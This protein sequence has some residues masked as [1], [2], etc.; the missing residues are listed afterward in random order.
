M[1]FPDITSDYSLRVT[2]G[3]NL[4]VLIILVRIATLILIGIVLLIIALIIALIVISV[5]VVVLL[6]IIVLLRVV[7]LLVI[8]V[9]IIAVILV[10]VATVL[11]LLEATLWL[12]WDVVLP[13]LARI[14]L[15][16]LK[17]YSNVG[18]PEPKMLQ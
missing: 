2:V 18:L 6:R 15:K 9:P 7:K 1:T 10:V 11:R 4:L 3:S 8:V 12:I 17:T 5:G 14:V 13:A 16:E